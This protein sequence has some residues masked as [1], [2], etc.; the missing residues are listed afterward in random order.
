MG[1]LEEKKH[2]N[3]IQFVLK[4]IGVLDKHIF[5]LHACIVGASG[6]VPVGQVA[7]DGCVISFLKMSNCAGSAKCILYRELHNVTSSDH[8]IYTYPTVH[9][10]WTWLGSSVTQ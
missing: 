3:I 2:W 6:S 4:G 8:C 7:Q 10:I 9:M 5:I 1:I